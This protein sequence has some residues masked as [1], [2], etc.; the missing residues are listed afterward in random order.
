MKISGMWGSDHREQDYKEIYTPLE[1]V[2]AEIRKRWNN[3]KLRR[4]VEDFLG[5]PPPGCVDA[6]RA[7]L[8]RAVH[9]PNLE[10][11]RFV[12]SARTTG[13]LPYAFAGHYDRFCST[14]PDKVGLL[15]L[16]L[17]TGTTKCD[18][19]LFRHIRIAD[20]VKYEGFPFHAIPTHWGESLIGFHYRLLRGAFPEV[21]PTDES[22][23]LNAR[24]STAKEFY[25]AVFARFVCHGIL[26]EN[27]LNNSRER[28]FCRDV[29]FPSFETVT[30]LFGV[31]PIVVPLFSPSSMADDLSTTYYDANAVELI[32]Q[33]LSTVGTT[34]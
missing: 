19:P 11:F 34:G 8:W 7:C 29:V 13:C 4:Q 9:T 23:W 31:R 26:F 17:I 32:N 27:Y 20:Q 6:P 33:A 28:V 18:K 24:G 22:S 12:E 14:N 21:T 5:G 25:P 30:T 15:R 2:G 10:F 3:I 1:Q 16:A